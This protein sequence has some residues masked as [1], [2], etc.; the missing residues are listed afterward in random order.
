MSSTGKPLVPVHTAAAMG[1]GPSAGWAQKVADAVAIRARLPQ[2]R[3]VGFD[4]P[5]PTS[6]PAWGSITDDMWGLEQRE[7]RMG[8]DTEAAG[9]M[10]RAARA[11]QD[12][13]V[14]LNDK[15]D[16]SSQFL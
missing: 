7:R 3:R 8:G 5:G 15:E 2:D 13:N 1:F 11:C 12:Y 4:L 6:L 9:W 10:N 14:P 16:C